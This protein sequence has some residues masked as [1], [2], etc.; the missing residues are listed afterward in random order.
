MVFN[1]IYAVKERDCF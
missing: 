1:T